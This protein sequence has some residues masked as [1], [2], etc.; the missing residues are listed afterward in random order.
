MRSAS[1]IVTTLLALALM[2]VGVKLFPFPNT[3]IASEVADQEIAAIN[4]AA[5]KADRKPLLPAD[6]KVIWGAGHGSGFYI[7]NDLF[8]TAAHVVNGKSKKAQIKS[9]DGKLRDFKVLWRTEGDLDIPLLK[10]NGAGLSSDSINCA[11]AAVGDDITMAGNPMTLEF[12]RT[13]GKVAGEERAWLH[14]SN[15]QVISA[16]SIPGQS[17]G[18]VYDKDKEVVGVFVGLQLVPSFVM[19]PTGYGVMIPSRVVCELL[20]RS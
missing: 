16:P 9:H 19:V 5:P 4:K 1:I 17:G 7:G 13:F 10:A 20:A 18:P 15:V 12:I 2:G 11:G 14:W 3:A 6:V 8:V